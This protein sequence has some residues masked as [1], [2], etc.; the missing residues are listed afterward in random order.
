MI[1]VISLI[2]FWNHHPCYTATPLP[3]SQGYTPETPEMPPFRAAGDPVV[4]PT[5]QLHNGS[6]PNSRETMGIGAKLD[7]S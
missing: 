3:S 2:F 6:Q 1:N 5:P 4:S 7:K